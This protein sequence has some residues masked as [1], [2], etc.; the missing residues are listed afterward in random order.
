VELSL[1]SRQLFSNFDR[2][3]AVMDADAHLDFFE[4]R[5][6]AKPPTKRASGYGEVFHEQRLPALRRSESRELPPL[7]G[8]KNLI[9]D[10][11]VVPA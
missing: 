10:L 4:P 7:W 5:L 8:A 11:T 1:K 6:T 3:H 9:E 2:V